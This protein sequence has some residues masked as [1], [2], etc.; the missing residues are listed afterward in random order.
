M[1]NNDEVDMFLEAIRNEDVELLQEYINGGF[2]VNIKLE[3]GVTPLIFAVTVSSYKVVKLLVEN[4]ADVLYTIEE[5]P[6]E[7]DSALSIAELARDEKTINL[8]RDKMVDKIV[9][10]YEENIVTKVIEKENKFIKGWVLFATIL[11]L[12]LVFCSQITKALN[13][14]IGAAE[15][16]L[17]IILDVVILSMCIKRS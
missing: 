4:G 1:E 11:V 12:I 3:D 14:E 7:G 10:G 16:S 2:D 13:G 6:M 17:Y 9:D 15:M 8:L 5:G